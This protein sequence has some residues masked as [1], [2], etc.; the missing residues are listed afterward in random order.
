MKA[1]KFRTVDNLHF[2]IDIIFNKRLFCCKTEL[3]ND[4]READ[5]RVG[6]DK[7]KEIEIIKFGKE[8]TNQI[9]DHRVCALSKTFNNHLLWAHYAGSYTGIAIE[10]ELEDSEITNVTYDDDYIFLS[11]LIE[12]HS[13]EEAARRILSKKY[14]AWSYEEEVRIITKSEFHCLA[15]PI[16]RIIVGSRTSSTLVSALYLICTHFGISLE[17]MVVADWGIYTVGSQPMHL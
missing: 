5:V 8:V 15:R 7:G 16:G 11:D 10:V 1:Y 3:L 12:K 13:P 4:I 6:N 2:V 17:R 9:K 14:K